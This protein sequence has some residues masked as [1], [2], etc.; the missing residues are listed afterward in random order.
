MDT[1]NHLSAADKRLLARLNLAEP[2]RQFLRRLWAR[3]P[4]NSSGYFAFT[5]AP[6]AIAL[7]MFGAALSESSLLGNFAAWATFVW[8]VLKLL[9][10]V[11]SATCGPGAFDRSR[12]DRDEIR[13]DFLGRGAVVAFALPLA[14]NLWTAHDIAVPV[15]TTAAAAFAGYPWV[16]LFYAAAC[17]VSWLC[18][19]YCRKVV[20]RI[21][22][23]E[24]DREGPPA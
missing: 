21:L 20:A 24:T 9:L 18:R 22:E 15:A 8:G 14:P 5:A 23:E 13:R 6:A 16:A 4:D 1:E 10:I 19:R 3:T 17:G 7:A 2:Q 12:D 11:G